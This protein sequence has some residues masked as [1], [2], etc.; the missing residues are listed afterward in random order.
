MCTIIRTHETLLAESNKFISNYSRFDHQFYSIVSFFHKKS[1]CTTYLALSLLRVSICSPISATA[2]LCFLRKLAKEDSCWIFASSRSLRSLLS[3]ASLF[4]LSSI[5]A[6][7][8][9]PASSRRSPSSSSSRARSL[10]CFS[11][12]ARPPR[13]ASIWE[14]QIQIRLSHYN[15]SANNDNII[16]TRINGIF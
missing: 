4:L 1:Y 12:L 16:L 2:S 8:A 6:E 11:A 3:S 10:R 7:V 13:S 14:R 9:P 15:V 5:W